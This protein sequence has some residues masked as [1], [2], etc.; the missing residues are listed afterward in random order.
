MKKDNEEILIEANELLRKELEEAKT[1]LSNKQLGTSTAPVIYAYAALLLATVG[2]ALYTTVIE[3]SLW[4]II[5][6]MF[7]VGWI[8]E[9][10]RY[11]AAPTPPR[12]NV[13]RTRRSTSGIRVEI[14]STEEPPETEA[15]VVPR[16]RKKAR[17]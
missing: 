16:V 15:Q 17:G 3:R 14:G 11:A 2:G 9:R 12:R 13:V 6:G 4:P 1:A 8:G 5:I 7:C 10:M